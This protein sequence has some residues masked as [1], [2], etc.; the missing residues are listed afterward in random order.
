MARNV[1][2]VFEKYGMQYTLKDLLHLLK[3]KIYPYDHI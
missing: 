1:D 2:T 3:S